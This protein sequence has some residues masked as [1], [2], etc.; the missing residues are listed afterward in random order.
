MITPQE[1]GSN[2]HGG[3]FEQGVNELISD[4]RDEEEVKGP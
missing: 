3:D 2:S 1:T 4:G